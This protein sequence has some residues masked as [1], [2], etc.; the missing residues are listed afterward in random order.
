MR[1]KILIVLAA[2]ALL[3]GGVVLGSAFDPIEKIAPSE[4]QKQ[5]TA[6]KAVAAGWFDAYQRKDAEA[7]CALYTKESLASFKID[8][9]QTCVDVFKRIF[10]ASNDSSPG[11]EVRGYRITEVA[12]FQDERTGTTVE[13]EVDFSLNGGK[14]ETDYQLFYLVESDDGTFRINQV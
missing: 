4:Q 5:E 2:C 3:A 13:A 9:S 1:K 7:L 12:F 10:G 6:A 11:L 14:V 8:F